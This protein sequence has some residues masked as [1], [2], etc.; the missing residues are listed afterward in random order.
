MAEPAPKPSLGAAL[1]KG[2]FVAQEHLDEAA[3][4]QKNSTLSLGQILVRSGRIAE[5]TRIQV[6][7]KTF[8]FKIF[9]PSQEKIDAEVAAAIPRPFAE[10]QRVYPVR[11]TKT[12]LVVAMEDPS[13]EMVLEAIRHQCGMGVEPMIATAKDLDA[14]FKYGAAGPPKPAA[15]PEEKKGRGRG[16]RLLKAWGYPVLS[17]AP[18][19]ALIALIALNDD[20]QSFLLESVPSMFDLGVYVGL[21]W[22]LYAILL[23]EVAGLVFKDDK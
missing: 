18:L 7:A 1:L 5:Q 9:I 8:G 2:G 12:A 4:E 16:Y 19:P 23:Y 11:K 13:D 10:T 15:K 21:G 3:E 20:F 14:L 6:L 22:G 17:V